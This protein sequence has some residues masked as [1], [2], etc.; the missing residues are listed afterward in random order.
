MLFK[1]CF[2]AKTQRRIHLYTNFTTFHCKLSVK[3]SSRISAS[4]PDNSQ[5][6]TRILPKL[7]KSFRKQKNLRA[8]IYICKKKAWHNTKSSQT[9]FYE[10]FAKIFVRTKSI[11]RAPRLRKTKR[12]NYCF[13]L[14]IEISAI[15]FQAN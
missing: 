15:L 6:I 5:N 11:A 14:R 2:A 13:S 3:I 8:N 4:D 1:C 10:I 9:F 7:T 12:K